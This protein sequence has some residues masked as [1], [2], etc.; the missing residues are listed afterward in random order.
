[1]SANQL[2][3]NIFAAG[4]LIVA[5]VCAIGMWVGHF[6]EM[7]Q[8]RKAAAAGRGHDF[9]PDGPWHYLCQK[10]KGRWSAINPSE[11]MNVPVECEGVNP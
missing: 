9:V 7:K 6:R 10:C 11:Y 1:M 5:F 2:V 4:F 3:G 8:R